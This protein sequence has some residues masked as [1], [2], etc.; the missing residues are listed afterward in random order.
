MMGKSIWLHSSDGPQTTIIDGEGIRRGILCASGETA[1]SIIEGFTIYNCNAPMFDYYE[2]GN[3][4]QLRLGGGLLI[5]DASPSMTNCILES[6]V[7]GYGAGF[8]GAIFVGTY[9]GICEAIFTDC[10]INGNSCDQN[11]GGMYSYYSN[12][13]L[14]NCEFKYNSSS[15]IGIGGGI[16]S[17][18]SSLM[19]TNTTVCGNTT[20]QING[21]WVDGGGNTVANTCP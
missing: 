7:A 9:V 8:G 5:K 10:T 20:D 16:C 14:I 17:V 15:P 11:G 13:R 3:P 21:S 2:D 1:N 19:L 18:E 12:H 6:N 4:Y